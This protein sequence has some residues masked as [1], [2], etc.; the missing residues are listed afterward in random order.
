MFDR[1]AYVAQMK[2]DRA[3]ID[4]LVRGLSPTRQ[5]AWYRLRESY[6]YFDGETEIE[7]SA[8]RRFIHERGN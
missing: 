3:E 1:D 2:R 8:L 5:E 6:E 4:R 7:L